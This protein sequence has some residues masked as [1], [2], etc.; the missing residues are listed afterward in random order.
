MK[1]NLNIKHNWLG[2]LKWIVF[3]FSIV[4]FSPF[5]ILGENSYFT[6][7]DNL[8]SEVQYLEVLKSSGTMYET[9]GT[10]LVQNTMNGIPR[11]A[12]K[13]GLNFTSFLFSF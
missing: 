2:I 3:C 10:N 12:Y 9:K 4:Y 7:H 1:N 5:L 13:S 8:D 11:A 6:V